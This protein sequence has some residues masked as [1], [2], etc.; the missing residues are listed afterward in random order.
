MVIGFHIELLMA[1]RKIEKVGFA[2][3]FIFNNYF[4]VTQTHPG[5][6]DKSKV[7]LSSVF[8]Q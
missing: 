4:E 8:N 1:A 2:Q 3:H 6:C 5:W 7:L